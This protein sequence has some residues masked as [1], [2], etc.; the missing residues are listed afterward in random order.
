MSTNEIQNAIAGVKNKKAAGP[1][2]YGE[3]RKDSA[4]LLVPIWT[5]LYN[6]CVKTASMSERWR[7]STII[8]LYK[9]KT[10]PSDINKYIDIALEN[11]SFKIFS[12]VITQ[13]IQETLP[14]KQLGFRKGIST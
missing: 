10:G 14:E 8:K 11:V 2:I 12:K 1:D 3:Y 13:R 9:G 7:H 4:H 5:K 6:K